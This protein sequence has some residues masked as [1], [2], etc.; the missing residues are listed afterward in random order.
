MKEER[1]E[2]LFELVIE[3]LIKIEDAANKA[4]V[5]PDEFIDLMRK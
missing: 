5:F 2:I 1:L 3:G 4:H